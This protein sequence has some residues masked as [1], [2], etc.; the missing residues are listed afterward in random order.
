MRDGLQ[1]QHARIGGAV[2]ILACF[3]QPGDTRG[4]RRNILKESGDAANASNLPRLCY[5]LCARL[6][7]YIHLLVLVLL[8]NLCCY[9]YPTCFNLCTMLLRLPLF[10]RG[11]FCQQRDA[12]SLAAYYCNNYALLP[13][14]ATQRTTETPAGFVIHAPRRH[15]PTPFPS[16]DW[17]PL[18]P[19]ALSPHPIGSHFVQMPPSL[20]RLAAPEARGEPRAALH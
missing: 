8:Y 12:R 20:T 1:G 18:P 13:V 3:C 11:L 5:T 14:S 10:I 6:L 17:L 19:D 7:C 16:P 2:L 15:S 4:P 9:Y